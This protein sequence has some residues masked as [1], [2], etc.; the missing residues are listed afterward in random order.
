MP[1]P[2]V[3]NP[4]CL[5]LVRELLTALRN[6]P[7]H[8]EGAE[9]LARVLGECTVSVAHARA[10][11]EEFDSDCPTPREIKDVA[12]RLREQYVPPPKPDVPPDATY[13]PG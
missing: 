8:P 7:F 1:N 10:V 3:A 12:Y 2:G 13:K 5:A 4:V 9:R 11:L 6:F